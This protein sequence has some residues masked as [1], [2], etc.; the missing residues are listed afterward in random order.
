MKKI[1]KKTW[2]IMIS[3]LISLGVVYYLT[4]SVIPNVM[5]T[6]TKAAPATKVSINQSRVLGSRILAKADGLDKCV[7]NIF[8]MDESGKGVKGKTAD[9]IAVDSGVDIRQMNAVTDDN[10]KIAYELTS[11]TEGQYRV[12]AM[13]DGV[14]VGKTITVTFRN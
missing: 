4:T 3:A 6:L 5:V 14:P 13:V 1:N 10:G 2:L 8:L 9:L 7:V 12:E 11:L